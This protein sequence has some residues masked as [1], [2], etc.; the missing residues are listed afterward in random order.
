MRR[1]PAPRM[2][3][4]EFKSKIDFQEGDIV[5]IIAGRAAGRCAEIIGITTYIGERGEELF[6]YRLKLSDRESIATR[7]GQLRL[8]RHADGSK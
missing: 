8:I 4:E 1:A 2:T 7:A 5:Q 6:S 3:A